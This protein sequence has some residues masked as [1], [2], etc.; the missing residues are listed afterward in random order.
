MPQS[1]Y[2]LKQ[3]HFICIA[4]N[5]CQSKNLWLI[6]PTIALINIVKQTSSSLR[7]YFGLIFLSLLETSK[8]RN[9][10]LKLSIIACT[11]MASTKDQTSWRKMMSL[12][13]SLYEYVII[14]FLVVTYGLFLHTFATCSQTLLWINTKFLTCKA[15]HITLCTS[16]MWSCMHEPFPANFPRWS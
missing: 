4:F 3:L 12:P 11:Y 14:A 10:F 5:H 16:T 9:L 6:S 2:K 15:C 1:F 8:S 13:S 7:S